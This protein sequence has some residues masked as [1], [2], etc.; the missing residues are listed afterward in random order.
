M[1]TLTGY[2][3]LT[4]TGTIGSDIWATSCNFVNATGV[5]GQTDPDNLATVATG[6]KNLNGGSVVP[7]GMLAFMSSAYA[8]TAVRAAAVDAG[9]HKETAVGLVQ[10]GAPVAGTGAPVQAQEVACVISLLTG[11]PGRRYRG[12]M[13][14]PGVGR[15]VSSSRMRYATADCQSLADAAVQF[16]NQLATLFQGGPVLPPPVGSGTTRPVVVS[17]VD[18]AT[19]REV[20]QTSVGDIPDV[21]R[22][23]RNKEKETYSVGTLAG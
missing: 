8:I 7:A 18:G 3:R 4:L 20:L 14:W 16:L 10:L 9:T 13:Y 12:R 6:V 1:P 23:R 2:N 15:S 22:R 19:Y 21:Q 5:P 17:K 11:A